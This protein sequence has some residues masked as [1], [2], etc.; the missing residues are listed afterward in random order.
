MVVS[1]YVQTCHQNIGLGKFSLGIQTKLYFCDNFCPSDQNYQNYRSVFLSQETKASGHFSNHSQPRTLNRHA[2][3]LVPRSMVH[4]LTAKNYFLIIM[5]CAHK[6]TQ[7]NSEFELLHLGLLL[8]SKHTSLATLRRR[9]A[10]RLQA[11][12]GS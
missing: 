2:I 12:R 4:A 8:T 7:A 3:R 5:S 6:Q 9:G 11:Y 10:I 1:P